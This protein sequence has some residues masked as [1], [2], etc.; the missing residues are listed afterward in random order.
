MAFVTASG[1]VIAATGIALGVVGLR[2]N[3]TY[4]AETCLCL[5]PGVTCSYD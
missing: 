3:G 5:P 1:Y 4:N 2:M